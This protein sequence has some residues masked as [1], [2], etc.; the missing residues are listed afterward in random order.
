MVVRLQV[1]QVS[2]FLALHK[3]CAKVALLHLEVEVCFLA[4]LVLLRE[5]SQLVCLV[6]HLR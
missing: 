2:R 1:G 6:V 4:W 5:V 3:V